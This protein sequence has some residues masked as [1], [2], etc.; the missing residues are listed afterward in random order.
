MPS[1]DPHPH[2]YRRPHPTP[3]TV[4]AD[5][6]EALPAHRLR[7]AIPSRKVARRLGLN[8]NHHARV[9]CDCMDENGG[10]VRYTYRTPY[11]ARNDPRRLGSYDALGFVDLRVP[12]SALDLY[13][14]HLEESER[15]P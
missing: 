4:A 6:T 10:E 12:G 9:W 1:R 2:L 8:R 13:R 3:F 7:I 5:G 14:E 11:E 15:Q